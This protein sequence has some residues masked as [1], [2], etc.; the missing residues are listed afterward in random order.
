MRLLPSVFSALLLL[1]ACGPK[2][3]KS[4]PATP[5]ASQ[6]R[7]EDAV[8]LVES[9]PSETTFDHEDVR[10]ADVVWREMIDSAKATID[11]AQFYASEAEGDALRSSKLAP[12]IAALEKAISRGIKVRFLAD[13]KFEPTYPATL[14]RL[15]KAGAEVRTIDFSRITGGIQHAKYFVVDARES[16]VGSQNFDW[17]ALDHIQEIGARITSKPIA[18]ALEDIFAHDWRQAS[19]ADEERA[20]R[21]P[22][23]PLTVEARTHE[24]MT[25][26]ASPR[27][28]LPDA[29]RDE[30]PRLVALL[31]GAKKEVRL[32]V[33]TYSVKNR[34]GSDFKVLDDAIRRTAAR[35]VPVH[36][37]VSHWA[38][39]GHAK[40]SLEDLIGVENVEIRVL[41]IPE[42]SSGAIPFAR[43]AHAKYLV[44]DEANAWIGSSNWEGDYFERSRNVGIVFE[45]GALAMRL[46]RIFADGWRS[47][48][49]TTIMQAAA[50]GEA[51]RAP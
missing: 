28:S 17:R 45:G 21:A 38:M 15:R 1:S 19:N 39:K 10:N 24:K 16:Y 48:Y 31:D 33:L 51:P 41:K 50:A 14:E 11:I 26:V 34:D 13:T 42:H 2:V 29:N 30:L 6:A 32:Q 5:S 9:A 12:V 44:V 18:L 46:G 8:E 40:K 47:T 22:Q 23:R 37:L 27:T 25:L 3:G 20:A 7:I 43:V 36:I 49:T 4:T 35:G